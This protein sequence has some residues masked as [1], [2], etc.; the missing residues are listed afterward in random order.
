M[1]REV[2]IPYEIMQWFMELVAQDVQHCRAAF[3]ASGS[4]TTVGSRE[5]DDPHAPW[6]AARGGRWCRAGCNPPAR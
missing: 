2:S 5:K 4:K 3:T 1:R 6:P